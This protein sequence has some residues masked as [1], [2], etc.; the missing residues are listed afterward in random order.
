MSKLEFKAKMFDKY[1]PGWAVDYMTITLSPSEARD[2][3][4]AI[5]DKHVKGL[6][7][8]SGYIHPEDND[9]SWSPVA[10][11]DDTHTARLEAME[12]LEK[13]E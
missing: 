4:Q 2:I 10:Q 1:Q 9:S 8:V 13:K 6:P 12:K 11:E 3:A 7:K 5:Y